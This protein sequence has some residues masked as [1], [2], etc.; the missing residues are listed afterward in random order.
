MRDAK[1]HHQNLPLVVQHDVLGFEVSV[2]DALS[3]RS[4]QSAANLLHNSYRF[5]RRKLGTVGQDGFQIPAL[6]VLHG[7]EFEALGLAEIEDANYVFMGDLTRQ[8]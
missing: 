8:D 6:D 7:D 3:V 4:V 1:I 2:D 5:F